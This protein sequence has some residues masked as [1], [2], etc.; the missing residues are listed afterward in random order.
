MNSTRKLTESALLTSLFIVITIISVG[1][2]IGYAAY[3]DFVVPVFFCIICLKCD[4]KYAILSSISSLIIVSLV[5]GNIGSAIWMS[6]GII[7]GILC[8]ILLMKSTTIIDDFIYGSIIGV[9]LMVLIDIYASN[10]IGYSFMEEF[11]GYA[12]MLHNKKYIDLLYYLL[13][14]L[15]PMGTIFSVY[16]LSLLLGD[17]L[18]ILK[19]NSKKK[20]YMI[21]YFKSC[22]RYICCSNKVFYACVIY[23]LLIEIFN[24]VGIKAEQTYIKTILISSEYICFYFIIRDAFILIQ[25]YILLKYNKPYYLRI[26]SILVFISLVFLF[27]VTAAVLIIFNIIIN[28]KIDIRIKQIGLVNNYIDKLTYR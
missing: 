1:T 28:K 27:K 18:R 21:K 13:I 17:K 3:L 15:L 26:F 9:M 23:I 5:L 16:F 8:G 24:I 6:Q 14:A 19:N 11:K 12:N 7:L 2:G 10:L 22:G 4:L 20:L 25:N